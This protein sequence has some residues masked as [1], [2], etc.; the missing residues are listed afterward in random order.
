MNIFVLDQ[1]PRIAAQMHCDKHVPKMIIEHAQMMTAAY[2]STLGIS[3]KKEIPDQQFTVNEMFAGWPRKNADGSEWHYAIS[4]VNHPCTI[5]TRTS[6]EN[7]N[8][9]LDC[10]EELCF[11]F[12]RRWGGK[13]S[14]EKIVDWMR[15]NPPK[16]T[17]SE[18]TP[19]A[20]AMPDCYRTNNP[21]ESYRRYY[22]MKTTYMKVVW[23]RGTQPTW[24]SDQFAK[25]CVNQYYIANP[26]LLV[27]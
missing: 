27:G 6:I 9:L 1:D 18:Q 22:G 25:D 8:W 20:M 15:Q 7:F 24:W 19:F 16:L 3:R 23:V 5:W 17:S 10:T 13:H 11:E 14:I 26:A 4:H 2:Y 12:T 21:V